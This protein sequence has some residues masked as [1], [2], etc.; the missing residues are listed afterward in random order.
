MREAPHEAAPHDPLQLER[1]IAE[2][3]L[4][5]LFGEPEQR[6][7]AFEWLREM[8]AKLEKEQ[9]VRDAGG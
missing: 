7:K 1:D 8:R 2:A 4:T 6:R 9:G 5:L 3:Q